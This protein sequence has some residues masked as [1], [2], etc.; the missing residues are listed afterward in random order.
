MNWFG[1][2]RNGFNLKNSLIEVAR[3]V[4]GVKKVGGRKERKVVSG[5]IMR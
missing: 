3:H 5:R 2:K 1:S 4:C